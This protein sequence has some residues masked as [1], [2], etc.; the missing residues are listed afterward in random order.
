MKRR[1]VILFLCLYI[2]AAVF[3][4]R[5]S[6]HVTGNSTESQTGEG[7]RADIV[8]SEPPVWRS[9][10]EFL[11]EEN[12][13]AWENPESLIG[14]TASFNMDFISRFVFLADIELAE[15]LDTSDEESMSVCTSLSNEEMSALGGKDCKFVITEKV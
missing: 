13:K 9:Y 6:V 11:F 14:C 8:A 15:T 2:V 4:V 7:G 5:M 3:A 12:I 10:Q 1:A